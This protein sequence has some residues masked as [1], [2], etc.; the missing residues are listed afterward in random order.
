MRWRE[1][2]DEVIMSEKF[3]INNDWKFS[4]QFDESML[5]PDYDDSHLE[6]VR[7]PHTVKETPFNGFDE[8]I[9]QM[10]SAYRKVIKVPG[11]F[12]S[13]HVLLVFEG[14]AHHATVFLNGEKVAE[15]AC[16]YTAFSADITYKLKTGADNVI[17]VRVDSNETLNQPPFG[18]VIDYMT[19]GGIYRDV[20]FEVAHYEYIEDVYC[21][22]D[23]F[24]RQVRSCIKISN[25]ENYS[26]YAKQSYRIKDS[27]DEFKP[28][29]KTEM[30]REQELDILAEIPDIRLWSPQ[31]PVLYEI[32]TEIFR[33][34]DNPVDT[35][36]IVTGF[37]KVCFT[38]DGFYCNDVKTK[39]RG[40][41]RHQSFP[42]VGY[43]M[44]DSMQKNDADILKFE[45]G[46]N[47]VRTSH[48]PQSHAFL[49]RC[50]E[51]GL[52]VFTEIPGWQHIG[53]DKWKRQAIENVSEMILQY[54]NH[55]SIILWGVRINESQD[56][57]DF[58][59]ETN[60]VAHSL[61]CFRQTGGVRVHK[62]SHLYE[63]VYTYNDF[64]HAGNNAGC[65]KKRKVTCD[66]KKGY[67]ISEYNGHMFP[68]KT[69]DSEEHRLEHAI[70]HANV[71]DAVAGEA[72]IAGSFGW[73]MFD[74]NTHKDFGSGER[75]CYHGVMDMFRNP[76]L[77]ASV[78]ACE[79]ESEVTLSLSSTMD[80]GEHPGCNRGDTW[81]FSNAD[82]V[83][84][85]KND[86]FIK[87]YFK[88]DSP[89]R[90]LTH[91][92]IRIDDY[93]GSAVDEGETGSR[94]LKKNMKDALNAVA[95]YGLNRL[96]L[97][98]LFK[99]AGV[100]IAKHYN[101]SDAGNLYNKYVGDWG[102]KSTVYRFDAIKDGKVAKTLVKAPMHSV[103][104]EALCNS[105]RLIEGKTY[106]VAAVRIRAVDE[107]GNVIPF[108]NEPVTLEC[109][110][111]IEIIGPKVISL[112][113]GMFGTYVKSIGEAGE[114]TLTI[115]NPQCENVTLRF[116]SSVSCAPGEVK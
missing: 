76:K 33:I 60:K 1:A 101:F 5:E 83:K 75:I 14:V 40:L 52:F 100:A 23:S 41:N 99:I 7:L 92:P 67:L 39:L 38:E 51:L 22:W 16:G 70:R 85:Y 56:D 35:K 9:Y 8:K 28:L 79:S 114:G 98:Y 45:L 113:G 71:L 91:G 72:D 107:N 58:Y 108:F 95:L 3:Y 44:P 80:I 112:K 29:G 47:A 50:D 18:Y 102:G 30:F 6:T 34:S 110:G 86:R 54:R 88:S 19:Y 81:I 21:T 24:N 46:V 111:S 77:A 115:R 78:Y 73:C 61:D 43:A 68:T 97:K 4:E 90:N 25:E 116:T 37:R 36:T 55:P 65:D 84:M 82:S 89:Y 64:L 59:K 109:S 12:E 32:K 104:L 10:V 26:T 103:S 17:V 74:Y 49:E 20:Y 63:D 2:P 105:D 106:D 87:E 11:D 62:K 31:N 53:D 48:Y 27:G 15:H 66:K 69:Y 96:P 57:D 13:K 93:I 42:Y 94:R